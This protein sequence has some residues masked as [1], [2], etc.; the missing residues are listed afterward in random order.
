MLKRF[1]NPSISIVIPT[2]NREDSLCDTI[3]ALLDFYDQFSDLIIVDQ[4]PEHLPE[5]ISFLAGLPEKARIV[6]P[7]TAN[8]PEARNIGAR[9]AKGE[10][11]LYLDDDIKPMPDLISAHMRHY[12]D[13]TIGG[14]AGRLISPYGEIKELDPSYYTSPFP[15]RHVRF[16]QEWDMREVDS[17]PGGNMSFRRALIF[18]VGGFDEQFVGNA[19]REE[20][21]FC[22][23]LRKASYRIIFDPEAAV[24]HYWKTGG[25]CDHI[26]LGNPE[27]TSFLYYQD[28]VQNNVYFFLKHVPR[29]MI[30]DLLWELYRNHI[31]NKYNLHKGLKHF[32][33][34]HVAF[35][36]GFL[37]AYRAWSRQLYS[38]VKF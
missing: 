18:E 1:I 33:Y 32:Y 20:T 30:P 31:G 38:L 3:K 24:I 9:E 14:V 29:A 22:M 26:R 12:K 25:G 19:F 35:C 28:F 15:W 13:P 36:I 4:T 23:R 6:K 11:L 37:R 5:T 8:L 27:F 2:Y 17:S 10:I 7:Q 21:D 34:R 16:D